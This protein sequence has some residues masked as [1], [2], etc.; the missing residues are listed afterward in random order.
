MKSTMQQTPLLISTLMRY[1]TTV[2]ADQ[3]IVT[4]TGDGARRMSYSEVGTRAAQPEVRKQV[5]PAHRSPRC[6]HPNPR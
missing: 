4:W 3:E 1:G 5:M 2:H 6:S